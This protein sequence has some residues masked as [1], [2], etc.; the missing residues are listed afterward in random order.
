M[1]VSTH[2][3]RRRA[4][5]KVIKLHVGLLFFDCLFGWF[6]TIKAFRQVCALFHFTQILTKGENLI[7]GN[8]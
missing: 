3:H 1:G 4:V 6:S 8:D 7:K 2:T 5:T